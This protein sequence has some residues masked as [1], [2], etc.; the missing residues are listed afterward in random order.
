MNS[1][2]VANTNTYRGHVRLGATGA[3]V[4]IDFCKTPKKREH[5]TVSDWIR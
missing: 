4:P 5:R 1:S 2:A 3:I